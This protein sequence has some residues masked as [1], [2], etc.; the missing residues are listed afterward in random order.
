MK[1]IVLHSVKDEKLFY[2][3]NNPLL[4]T[5]QHIIFYELPDY[6]YKGKFLFYT[7]DDRTLYLCKKESDVKTILDDNNYTKIGRRKIFG[8]Y[9]NYKFSQF[10]LYSKYKLNKRLRFPEYDKIYYLNKPIHEKLHSELIYMTSD[11]L[12]INE[13]V[14]EETE[15]DE[16]CV[17]YKLKNKWGFLY[18]KQTKSGEY[19]FTFDAVNNWKDDR[20]RLVQANE[21]YKDFTYFVKSQALPKAYKI[22]RADNPD[23]RFKT[24]QAHNAR[25]VSIELL[26]ADGR[27]E[28]YFHQ[29]F[30]HLRISDSREWFELGNDLIDYVTKESKRVQRIIK[31]FDKSKSKKELL[32]KT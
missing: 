16:G 20:T 1:E 28:T 27:L 7:Q 24:I 21:G 18:Y 3:L 15:Q 12:E 26:L 29:K 32:Q 23:K 4:K 30:D 14:S 11:Y 2:D 9:S 22:G 6:N 8:D 25:D 19:E 10:K 5:P 13:Y 17:A 31:I